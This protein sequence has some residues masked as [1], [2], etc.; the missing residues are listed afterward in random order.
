[1]T[2]YFVVSECLENFKS[3]LDK[4]KFYPRVYV[5]VLFTTHKIITFLKFMLKDV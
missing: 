4:C 5:G 3:G 1:M 2:F